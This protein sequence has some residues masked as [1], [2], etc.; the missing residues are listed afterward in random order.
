[1]TFWSPC[2]RSLNLWKGHL[3]IPKR[4]QRIARYFCFCFLSNLDLLRLFLIFYHGKSPFIPPFGDCFKFFPSIL[5]KS[6]YTFIGF[7]G[8][9]CCPVVV[10]ILLISTVTVR[11][12]YVALSKKVLTN[13]HLAGQFITTNPPRPPQMVVKSKEGIDPK[14][15]WF[16]FWIP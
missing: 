12:E 14:M 16:M 9:F 2:W 8:C 1:M 11:N 13:A 3:A 4:S 7:W 15:A 6:K 5:C 10:E